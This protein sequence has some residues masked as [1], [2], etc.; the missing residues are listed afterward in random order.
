[1]LSSK[2]ISKSLFILIFLFSLMSCT[3]Q[4]TNLPA[5]IT[6]AAPVQINRFDKELFRLIDSGDTA[7]QANIIKQNPQMLEILGKGVLNMQSPSVPGF[8]D[9]LLNYYS[10]PT[11]KGLYGDAVRQFDNVSKIEQALGNGFAWLKECFPAMTIPAVYM[12]VSGFNQNVLVSEHL[13]SISIDKYLGENYPL[14][15]DFFYDF[16][17]RKMMPE[18]IVPDYLAGW[19][20][21]EYPFEGKENVLLDR[22]IYEGKIIYLIAL[23]LPEI[24][25]ELLL[26]YTNGD[27]NWCKENESNIWKAMIERKHL[28]TPDQMATSKYFENQPSTFLSTDAPGNLG[29]YTG[30]Q[31]IDKYMKE[32]NATPEALMKNNN[33]QEILTASKYKP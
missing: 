23:A 33:S 5:H 15:L 13:L 4:N 24:N 28:Y 21:S 32:T 11:L 14:Y 1:M 18:L 22:M 31:I 26:G 20:M 25:P 17:R 8:F 30:W 7:L 29:V 2:I 3:G 12:H 9:K 16:Q 6:S 10:E 19:L 27:Y